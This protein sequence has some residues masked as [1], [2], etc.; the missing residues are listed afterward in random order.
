[1]ARILVTSALPYINGVKHLGNLVGSMLPADVYARFQRLR[2]HDVLYICATDEHGTPAELAAEAAGLDVAEFCRQQHAIQ[3]DLGERFLLSW[4]HFGRSSSPQNRELTQHFARRLDANGLLEERATRQMYSLD[5]ERFL[6][7]R[8]LIGTCPHCGYDRARG[9]QCE[10]CTRVLDPTDLIEPRSAISGSARLEVRESRHL[11]LR[12]SAMVDRLRAWI[13][14]KTDWPVLVTSIARKWLDEGLQDRCITRDLAWGVPVDRPGFEEK[15]F[16]VWF[17]APIEYIAATA[18]WAALDP[19]SRDWRSWWYDSA[20]VY[21]VQFMAKDNVPFHTVGFPVTLF[22]SG[23]P[24]HLADM[25]KGVNWLNYYGDKFSTS[26]KRGIFMDRALELLPADHWRYTL[27]AN[28]PES[29]DA[30]F[31]WEGLQ[32]C[33]NKDLA[34]VFG[35]FVNRTLRFCAQK[36]GPQVPAGGTPGDDE[37]AL[38]RALDAQLAELTHALEQIQLRRAAAELRATW[39]LGNEYLQAAAPWKQLAT[40]PER[41]AVIIRTAINLARLFGLI[42]RPFIPDTAEKLLAAL[43]VDASLPWPER[44]ADHMEALPPGHPFEE[45]GVLFQKLSDAEIGAWSEQFAGEASALSA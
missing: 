31:T 3:R 12:Q 8:Y 26:Q 19:A 21:Y 35:N 22:G 28:T 37:A 39:V 2:G 15:V 43:G 11:Y 17:D 32:A 34:D 16:Y 20:D 25:I 42:A 14:T 5:D 33:V 36:M 7:D 38:G 18:E 10:S 24:W 1:M 45:P 23:E 4:N 30:S 13:D 29:S 44:A 6:P 41:A 40:D 9:D 27:I